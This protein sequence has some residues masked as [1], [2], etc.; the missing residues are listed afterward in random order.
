MG[1]DWRIPTLVPPEPPRSTHWFPSGATHNPGKSGK[2]TISTFRPTDCGQDTDGGGTQLGRQ[3]VEIFSQ[4]G[5]RL[6]CANKG[7]PDLRFIITP[8]TSHFATGQISRIGAPT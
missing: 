7:I 8:G 6:A 2:P 1:T 3:F 5:A 4:Y